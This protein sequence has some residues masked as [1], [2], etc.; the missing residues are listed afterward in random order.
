MKKLSLLL[1]VL[2]VLSFFAGCTSEE[3]AT[4][5][6]NGETPTTEEPAAEPVDI[7]LWEQMDPAAQDVFDQV[8]ADF[9]AMYPN[10]T[11]T[12]THY[13]TEELR[14]NFQTASLAGQGPEL[15]YGPS[16]NVGLFNVS[17][18]IQ[19]VTSVLEADFLASL[20][21]NARMDGYTSGEYWTVPDINGNQIAMLYNKA[22]IDKAP[23]TWEELVA[24]A[25]AAR[26][27]DAN[28]PDNST[29]GF[30]FNEK[31]P[32]W[33]VGFYNAFGGSVMDMDNNPTLDNDAMVK[34][35]QFVKDVRAK[36][37][38]G[39]EGMD[40]DIPDSLFKQGKAAI[41]LNGAW[42]WSSYQEAGIDLGI[43]PGPVLPGGAN[44]TF[45]NSTKGYMISADMDPAK[46]DAIRTFF[47]FFLSAE[48][49][50]K[51]ALANSQAPAVL[52]AWDLPEIKNDELQQASVAT[53][54]HTTPMPIVAEMRAVWDAMRPELEAVLYQDKAPAD[55]AKDMQQ[56]AV[57]GVATIR[58]E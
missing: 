42:S 23:E 46:A 53:I 13:E 15:V 19:P 7:A 47:D 31:E 20:D 21:E 3:P 58:G 30:L 40:Y 48:N 29:Y 49:N 57:E 25:T 28:N 55:A 17:G 56:R 8:A 22:M 27:I 33:F 38:L 6:T 12:R 11:V 36:E 16:D 51:F 10:I 9:M 41:I 37:G 32:F 39:I 50:A 44:M 45:Y 18:L 43:A 26:S 5:E 14:T 2:L 34:A 52:A 24:A 54:Q 35:L 4:P 1:V